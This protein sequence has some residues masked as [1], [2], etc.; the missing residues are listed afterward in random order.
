[1]ARYDDI[2][3]FNPIPTGSGLRIGVVVCRFNADVCEG[4]CLPAPHSC[5]N[6]AWPRQT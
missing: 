1:M 3:N 2:L 5:W 4:C 6:S